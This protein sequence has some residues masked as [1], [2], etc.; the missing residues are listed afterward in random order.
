MFIPF[1]KL[2]IYF[3]IIRC[4]FV[5][6]S[7]RRQDVCFL[8]VSV[9]FVF[10]LFIEFLSNESPTKCPTKSEKSKGSANRLY[11]QNKKKND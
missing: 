11:R 5:G 1:M 7:T 3:M 10:S 2:A 8:T 6:Q 4:E 9:F